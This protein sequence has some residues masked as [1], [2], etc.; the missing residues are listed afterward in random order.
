[1]MR[2]GYL[3]HELPC[4]IIAGCLTGTLYSIGFA[5][6][7]PNPFGI[8][9]DGWRDYTW[10]IIESVPIYMIY[11]VPI[12]M[13]YGILTSIISDF[14]ANLLAKGEGGWK[15]LILS[16]VLHLF[17]G[18]VL[19]WASLFAAVLFFLIDQILRRKTQYGWREA[20]LSLL[21]P[22]SVWLLLISFVWV[23]G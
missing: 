8:A 17:F 1:M 12:V 7:D 21:I 16:A 11:I 9:L 5:L 20:V 15:E 3:V 18:M 14:I 10:Q 13:I 22:I 4:K 6:F 19:R 2:N 23:K